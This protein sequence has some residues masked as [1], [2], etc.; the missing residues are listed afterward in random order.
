MHNSKQK[1]I[2]VRTLFIYIIGFMLIVPTLLHAQQSRSLSPEVR[3]VQVLLNGRAGQLPVIGLGSAD[4]LEVSFDL[5]SHEYERF[6]YRLIH[7]DRDWQPTS[8]I[9]L[10]DAADYTQESIPVDDYEYSMN[11]TQLYTHYRF[12][13]PSD[14]VRPRISGNYRVEISRDGN[15]EDGLVAEACFMVSEQLASI[16]ITA[17]DNTEIDYKRAH[18]QVLMNVDYSRLTPPP[19]N[20]REELTTV[21]LQNLRWDNAKLHLAPE[22]MTGKSLRWEHSRALIFPAGNEY[23]KFE[24]TTT[25]HVAMGMESLRWHEPYYHAQLRLGEPRRNYVYDEDQNG[26][27]VIRTTDKF[28]NRQQ[29]TDGTDTEVS[30]N[31]NGN[32]SD[33]E[34]DYML[35]HFEL[36]TEPLPEDQHI[37]VQG[38]WTN[39]Y[40]CPENEMHYDNHRGI[41]ECVMLLKQGYYNYQFLVTDSAEHAGRTR[42]IEG[43]FYE[44]ENHYS[45]LVYYRNPFNRYD[46]LIGNK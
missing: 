22:Y 35:V 14:D 32:E 13:I 33:T 44:T 34:A 9:N 27:C 40:L 15:Y 7:C 12:E 37:Y 43:D 10:S 25:R 41:Y 18:Q 23:R 42:P 1:Q 36:A 29:T 31:G 17:T 38:Q 2:I 24:N 26:I 30:V 8:G 16:V 39:D 11:T 46:R 20:P 3:T 5:L 4:V 19:S 45:A 21:V 6:E 28:D